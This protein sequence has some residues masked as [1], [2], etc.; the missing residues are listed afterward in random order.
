[1]PA[2]VRFV[3]ICQIGFVMIISLVTAAD[4]SGIFEDDS[5]FQMLEFKVFSFVF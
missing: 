4:K 2:L 3:F 5:E 1:M